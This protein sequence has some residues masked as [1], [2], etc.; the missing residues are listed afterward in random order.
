M[1]VRLLHKACIGTGIRNL[2][3]DPVGV[4]IRDTPRAG[5]ATRTGR[6][7]KGD[8]WHWYL[9]SFEARE[10]ARSGVRCGKCSFD[11]VMRMSSKVSEA[12]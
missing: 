12:G 8:D 11:C 10:R 4:S 3:A 5:Q 1:R 7:C 6:F 2:L 9:Q